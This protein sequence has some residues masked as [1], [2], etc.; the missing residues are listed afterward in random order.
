MASPSSSDIRFADLSLGVN[1]MTCAACSTRLERVLG[2]VEGV[3]R[4]LVS[5]A[6]ERADIRYDPARVSPQALEAAIVRAGFAPDPAR[7]GEDEDLDRAEAERTAR[8]R[9]DIRLLVLSAALTLPLMLDMG[10]E[11]AGEQAL[12][13]PWGQLVL[14]T[15]V[16]F[17]I[18]AR[19]Y[20]GAWASL[21]GGA[22]NMDVLVVMGTSAAFGL[23][24]FRVL[25]G[26]A[27]HGNLYFE[28]SA[29]VITLVLLGKALENRARHS[30]A[31]SIRALM[32]LKPATAR[33]ERD[34]IEIEV[35]A[36][37]VGIG[38]TVVIRPGERVPVDGTI[39]DGDS[40]LDESL[41][42]GESLPV[43]RGK[44]DAVVAGSVNGEGLLRVAATGIGAES[45]IGRIIRLV[46]G[47]Q[48]SKAPVQA[49]VDRVSAIFVPVV[50]ALAAATFLGWW[51]LADDGAT[52]FVAAI[53]VLVVACPCALGL[54]TPAGIM[55]GTGLA[56]RHG[57]LIK[58]AESLERAHKVAAIAF[59]K[60]GTLTEGHPALA[61][62]CAVDGDRTALL[63]LVASAQQ[64]SEHPL[65]R[66]TVAAAEGLALEP[67]NDFRA[68]PGRGLTA[69]VAGQSVIIGS[70]RL[71]E[72][73]GI[74]PTPLAAAAEA[75]EALGHTLMWV[76]AGTVL[77]GFISLADPIRP[78]AAVAIAALKAMGIVPA[79]LTGD[80]PRAAQAVARQV[81]I[82]RV[83][84][85][86]LPED[87]VAE[88]AR[89]RKEFGVV[90]MVGD[91]IND[92]PALAAADI[93]IAMGGGSDAAMQAA[94][95]TLM[96]SDPALLPQALGISRATAA[97]IRQNLIWAFA[98]NLIAL[99]AA[100]A[101][102]LSPAIAGA[103]MALSSVSVVTNALLLKRWRPLSQSRLLAW[104]GSSPGL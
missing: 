92:A 19:F 77:V 72:E 2:R 33:V 36:S 23:S 11:M 10:L 70:R 25:T 52:G 94:G 71:M 3:E 48:A 26:D 5:L 27:H 85:G 45:T 22:G 80:S 29:T 41:V 43:E 84:A 90:A 81:G 8:G 50:V 55:V 102:L 35:P 7:S 79:M 37:L 58:D 38:E 15:L 97:K 39:L 103:A 68:L 63:R 12:L 24:A 17:A 1:G 46:R 49:L 28:G 60:T 34:G 42:T 57:I 66:A 95:L 53:S 69:R 9:R 73:S 30:A 59:D 51:G 6:A 83:Y 87:K 31:G 86:I 99:P 18:G 62:L 20:S 13:P 44:G 54:A 104:S 65:G 14:A 47:A 78:T 98:Y 21:R 75:E 40:T 61:T 100:A 93:G 88:L 67:V 82:E 74:D 91:G 96:R 64:G 89:L 4:A 76:A 16:Q 32:R 56:A 101:G